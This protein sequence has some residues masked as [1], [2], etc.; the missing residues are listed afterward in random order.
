MHC[1]EG[2]RVIL[3]ASLLA[4]GISRTPLLCPNRAHAFAVLLILDP[5][6]MALGAQGFVVQIS[7]YPNQALVRFRYKSFLSPI[8]ALRMH[9][10][11]PLR[12]EY[13]ANF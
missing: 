12:P 3:S 5:T 7:V 8:T 10:R 13:E 2:V 11:A 6:W 1:C 9:R 4:R